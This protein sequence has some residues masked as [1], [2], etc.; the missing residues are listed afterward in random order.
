MLKFV[1]LALCLA[2][3]LLP[4]PLMAAFEVERI[5][6]TDLDAAALDVTTNADDELVYF[7][8]PGTV[9]IYSIET[10]TVLDR[11]PVAKEF[12]RIAYE[13]DGRLVLTDADSS[14][15]DILRFNRIYDI[16]ISGRAVKG[17]TDARVTL[18]V[19]DDYQ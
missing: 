17:P 9:L 18:A 10:Q 4:S 14:R 1:K 12:D 5:L 3:V 8:T 11:I 7:L 13:A 19:F 15:I 2:A 16:D 6:S